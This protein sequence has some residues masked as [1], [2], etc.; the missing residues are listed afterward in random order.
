MVK[1]NKKSLF[2][3][4]LIKRF[5][6]YL[7][8]QSIIIAFWSLDLSLRPYL[9]KLIINELNFIAVE[10]NCVSNVLTYSYLYIGSMAFI[11]LMSCLYD[12]I[13]MCYAP[14][15]KAHISK[16]LFNKAINYQ[17]WK[18]MGN[19]AITNRINDI[20]NGIPVIIK[21]TIDKFFGNSLALL[22]AICTVWSVN[23]K[24]A[25]AI[26][27]WVATY[28][29]ASFKFSKNLKNLAQNVAET[30]SGLYG[31]I[32]DV[33]INISLVQL[34]N[35]QRNE[36]NLVSKI[37][38]KL[39][40]KE[41]I[42]D[43]FAI[44]IN[45]FQS[46]SFIILQS[47]CL[48][49]LFNGI[50][51]KSFT[52]GD[53]SLILS[54]NTTIINYM[55]NTGKDIHDFL[56]NLG[57]INQSLEI[58]TGENSVNDSNLDDIEI[59]NGEINF[60]NVYFKHKNSNFGFKNLSLT[61]QPKEKVALVGFSGSGKSTF[62]NLILG[63]FKPN[64]GNIIIDKQ[65]ISSRNKCSLREAIAVI[66]QNTCILNRSI[67]DNIRYAKPRASNQ[68]VIEAAKKAN[69]HR[70]ITSIPESYNFILGHEGSNLSSGQ[71]QR[72]AI[73]RAFLK[74]SQ[75]MIIDEATS[76]LDCVTEN[77]IQQSLA[78]LTK[79]K[80]TIVI[81]HR[82]R[83]LLQMDRILVFD[84]GKIVEE[85]THLELLELGCTYKKLWEAQTNNTILNDE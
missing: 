54:I 71:R 1:N 60:K 63:V 64:Q 3:L 33:L 14:H 69:A 45:L 29:I 76:N 37:L 10:K 50:I 58:I 68:E 61:I 79:N 83:T 56:D 2:F 62:I 20:V 31:K 18:K 57:N 16:F 75:I 38:D 36:E 27:I 35:R 28:I 8:L 23:I 48:W 55:R 7:I 46:A 82:L 15:I 43:W 73:A 21:I 13:E 72:I 22:I 32:E 34:Y 52:I 81:A 84:N 5:L 9:I 24:F 70:F 66:P 11:T 77:N 25:C 26:T 65:D 41:N 51:D 17:D 42:R 44:K 49:W 6:P 4:G 74:N 47:V 12:F 53:C 80:T 67:D 19:E 85:G 40:L 59:F 30:R 78:E 39:I